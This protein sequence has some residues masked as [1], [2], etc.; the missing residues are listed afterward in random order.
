MKRFEQLMRLVEEVVSESNDPSRTIPYHA[1]Y[2]SHEAALSYCLRLAGFAATNN[3]RFIEI[4]TDSGLGALSM[5]IAS[6]DKSIVYSCDIR[7]ECVDLATERARRFG[8]K[9]TVFIHGDARTL[10][11]T[12]SWGINFAYIDGDHSYDSC[13]DDLNVVRDITHDFTVIAIDDFPDPV[14][15][16][17]FGVSA[18]ISTFLKENPSYYGMMSHNGMYLMSR[19]QTNNLLASYDYRLN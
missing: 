11:K 16:K 6:G 9:N 18:A 14:F 8:L 2:N 12:I 10:A 4:G 15:G 3:G 5:A 13:L 19:S 7:K 17:P 1:A